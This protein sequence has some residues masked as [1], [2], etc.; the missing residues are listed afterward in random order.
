M[1]N[2][3]IGTQCTDAGRHKFATGE[4]RAEILLDSA[5]RVSSES[6]NDGALIFMPSLLTGMDLAK[7]AQMGQGRGVDRENDS[8]IGNLAANPESNTNESEADTEGMSPDNDGKS[9]HVQTCSGGAN[10]TSCS[11]NLRDNSSW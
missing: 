6:L 9:I 3:L 1:V 8:A 4:E 11:R 2:G 5:V 7:D 10:G